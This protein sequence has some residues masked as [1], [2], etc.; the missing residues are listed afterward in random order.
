MDCFQQFF[1]FNSWPEVVLE[2]WGAVRGPERGLVTIKA[3]K[4]KDLQP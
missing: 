4:K 3:V 2:R 1:V